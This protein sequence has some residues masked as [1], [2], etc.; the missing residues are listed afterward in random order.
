MFRKLMMGA[1]AAFTL[2][3]VGLALSL[4]PGAASASSPFS[5]EL[6]VTKDCPAYTGQAGDICTITSSNL[7]AIAEG[8]TVTYARGVDAPALQLNSNIVLDD[9]A[10]NTAIGHCRLS[11]VTY[12]GQCTFSGGTGDLTGFHARVAVSYAGGTAFA[13]DGTYSFSPPN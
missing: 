5:G 4:S 13:W 2:G 10:G 3:L 11:L 7:D 12:L 1:F 6:H 9:G 8:S